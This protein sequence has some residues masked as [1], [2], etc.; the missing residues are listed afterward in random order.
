MMQGFLLPLWSW[1]LSINRDFNSLSLKLLFLVYGVTLIPKIL[2]FLMVE[3]VKNS[4]LY[5]SP[6]MGVV[7]NFLFVS[8]NSDIIFPHTEQII[9]PES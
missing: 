6:H 3:W 5:S 7:M 4:L 8:N 2:V 9:M 1:L